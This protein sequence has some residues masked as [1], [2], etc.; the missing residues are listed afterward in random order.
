MI[1]YTISHEAYCKLLL[2]SIKFHHASVSG[3]L[4]GRISGETVHIVD[5]LPLFHSQVGAS[6]LRAAFLQ[7]EAYSDQQGCVICGIYVANEKE[8]DRDLSSLTKEVAGKVHTNVEG[9]WW[10]LLRP[11]RQHIC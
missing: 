4:L 8:N 10:D 9:A 1:S 5:V 11:R 2:H 3:C 7:S 6:L